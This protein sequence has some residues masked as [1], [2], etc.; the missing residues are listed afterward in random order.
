MVIPPYTLTSEYNL[1]EMLEHF[2]SNYI[3]DVINNKINTI[4]YASTLSEPN[5][6]S[7]LEEEFKIMYERFPDDETNT[8]Q[9]RVQL[10]ED[11]I[12]LLCDRF[13][14]QFTRK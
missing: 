13:N 4:N 6:V 10:Y 5:M 11:I 7:S 8:K 3:M 12:H 9:I 1:A 14:L 2:D